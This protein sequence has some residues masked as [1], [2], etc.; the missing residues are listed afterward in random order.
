MVIRQVKNGKAARLDSIPAEALKSDVEF[1]WDACINWVDQSSETRIVYLPQLLSHIRLKYLEKEMLEIQLQ[2]NP[3]IIECK[4][5]Q[6]IIRYFLHNAYNGDDNPSM[7]VNNLPARLA[8][9]KHPTLVVLG[10]LNTCILNCMQSFSPSRTVWHT[11]PSMPVDSL[12]WFSVAVIA[13]T[14]FVIGG[15]K[16]S[17]LFEFFKSHQA[18]ILFEKI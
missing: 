13:N 5:A 18:R 12:A 10:G 7:Y 17:F 14:L 8:T 3:L 15:I 6:N 16:V 9:L 4:I 2:E 11:C 1:V